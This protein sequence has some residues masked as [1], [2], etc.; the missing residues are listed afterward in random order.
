MWGDPREVARRRAERARGRLAPEQRRQQL[1][2]E[3]ARAKE[4]AARAKAS[5]TLSID[6]KGEGV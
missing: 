4:A 2:E 1:A 5:G 3:W 6:A